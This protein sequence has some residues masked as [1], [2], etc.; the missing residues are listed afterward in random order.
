LLEVM[1]LTG[2]YHRNAQLNPEALP[3]TTLL[4]LAT[5]AGARAL[6]FDRVGVIAPG[7]RAD[8]I[9]FD[10]DKPHWTPR[11][12]LAANIVYAAHPSDITHVLCDGQWLLRDGRLT[13]LDEERILREAEQRAFRMVGAPL[14]QLREYRA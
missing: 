6:G 12:D 14:R 10:T 1:R 11:H 13:T 4:R 9:L 5:G 7:Q 8:V 3:H 2:L